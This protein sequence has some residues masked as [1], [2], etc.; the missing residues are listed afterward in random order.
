MPELMLHHVSIPTRDVERAVAFYG[1]IF[2]L[3]PIPRPDFPVEGAWLACGDRQIHLVRHPGATFRSRG[4]DNDDT[5]FAFRT[6]D[7]E[8]IVVRLIAHG[9]RENA[10][11]DD[12]KR[13]MLK[14]QGRAGFAQLYILD[15][16]GNVIEVNDA[17]P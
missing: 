8:T 17:D 6:D 3:R 7:F 11:P 2:G 12:P 1:D 10:G 5:H 16:D 15:P 13:M 4:V 9:Y 14:R